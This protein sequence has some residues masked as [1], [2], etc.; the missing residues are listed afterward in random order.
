M[1]SIKIIV[2]SFLEFLLKSETVGPN[3]LYVGTFS[4]L[5]KLRDRILECSD[6]CVNEIQKRSCLRRKASLSN[7]KIAEENLLNEFYK[8]HD[9][10]VISHAEQF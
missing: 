1:F 4:Y 8:P 2:R 3:I 5:K 9:N 6:N 10:S 7:L